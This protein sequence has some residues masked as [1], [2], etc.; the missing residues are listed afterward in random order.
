MVT[1]GVLML[2]YVLAWTLPQL[3]AAA[4][5]VIPELRPLGFGREEIAAAA[6]ALGDAGLE[7]YRYVHRSSGLFAPV[8]VALGW[9]GM[10]TLAYPRGA[11]RWAMR[12]VPVLFAV[13]W[14]LGNRTV[15]A[16]LADPEG[17]PVALASAL[18]IARWALL[19]LLAAQA[20]YLLVRL[21]RGKID[22]FARGELV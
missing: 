8:L 22:A 14:V 11:R 19:V 6:A 18:V 17:G 16:A 5:T 2:L 20:V 13:V 1:V 21:V 10:V 3:G 12:A 7:Q 15:D 4:G 9:L